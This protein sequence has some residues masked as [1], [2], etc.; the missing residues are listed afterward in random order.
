MRRGT[1]V[2]LLLGGFL[3]VVGLAIALMIPLIAE[4][5]TSFIEA[6]PGLVLRAE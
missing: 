2:G 6:L 3:L 5:V 4:E 1:A